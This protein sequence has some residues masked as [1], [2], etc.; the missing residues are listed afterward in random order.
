MEP[1]AISL[2]SG[3]EN[4]SAGTPDKCIQYP[5][6]LYSGKLSISFLNIFC[7]NM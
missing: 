5:I 1:G 3:F 6:T 7:E 4:D 2:S